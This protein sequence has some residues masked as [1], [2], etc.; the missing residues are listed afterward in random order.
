MASIKLRNE[1]EAD[2]TDIS[3]EEYRTY[4]FPGGETQTIEEPQFLSVS[5]SGGHRVINKAEESFYIKP[6]W[7]VIKWKAKADQPHFVK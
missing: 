5:K 2:F 7:R 1:T 4:V 6:S 3:S